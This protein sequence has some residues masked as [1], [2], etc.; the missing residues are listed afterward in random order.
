M[1]AAGAV[2]SPE[3]TRRRPARSTSAPSGRL[4]AAFGPSVVHR[5]S[6]GATSSG[7]TRADLNTGSA[8]VSTNTAWSKTTTPGSSASRIWSDT[9]CTL[10]ASSDSS[11]TIAAWFPAARITALVPRS[12]PAHSARIATPSSWSSTR[13]SPSARASWASQASAAA[14]ITLLSRARSPR[15]GNPAAAAPL[16]T[17]S[18]GSSE[19]PPAKST[20]ARTTRTTRTPARSM[21]G[22]LPVHP[23][24]PAGSP[25]NS[26]PRERGESSGGASFATTCRIGSSEGTSGV[27]TRRR[28]M[29]RG[30]CSGAMKLA[31]GARSERWQTGQFR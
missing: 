13:E 29:Q 25:Y 21:R 8:S 3:D 23:R 19:D 2:R 26:R 17:F 22:K 27:A 31:R 9:V 18:S 16:I 24:R 1:T 30:Q 7:R 4:A 28:P 10:A 15:S 5:P 20:T 14:R 6:S 12:R 11:S